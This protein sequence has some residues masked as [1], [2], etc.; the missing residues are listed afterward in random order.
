MD[1]VVYIGG[2]NF[3]N[4]QAFVGILST[5][6]LGDPFPIRTGGDTMATWRGKYY[7][8]SNSAV[9]S[10]P[11]DFLIDFSGARTIDGTDVGTGALI[12]DLRFTAE[13]IITGT[14][15]DAVNTATASGLIGE[16][17]LVGVFVDKTPAQVGQTTVLY[18]G[19]V[20]DNPN[21]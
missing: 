7:R 2:Y 17:G 9:A 16:E 5:T 14:A 18:G 4:Y 13:G 12:F 15:T 1:G 8:S 21:P 20:A 11:V 19:F 10:S 3:N 6:N